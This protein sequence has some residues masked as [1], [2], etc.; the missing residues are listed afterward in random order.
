VEVKAKTLDFWGP[1][2]T[3]TLKNLPMMEPAKNNKGKHNLFDLKHL[4]KS[5]V[6]WLSVLWV[7]AVI[8]CLIYMSDFFSHSVFNRRSFTLWV[9]LIASGFTLVKIHKNYNR[10]KRGEEIS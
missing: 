5:K 2:P 4:N 9:I 8:C 7:L 3:K 10:Q 6:I 1:F